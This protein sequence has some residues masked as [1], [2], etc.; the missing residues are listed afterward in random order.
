M[1]HLSFK[2]K[3][4]FLGLS[5]F[6]FITG[7]SYYTYKFITVN[8]HYTYLLNPQYNEQTDLQSAY[9]IKGN[10]V[11]LG[12]SL[13]YRVHWNELLGRSDVINRGIGSDIMAGYLTRLQYVFNVNP[14]ICFVEGGIND[15]AKDIAIDTIVY[16][17]R[18]L[19]DTLECHNIKVVLNSTIHVAASYPNSEEVN[20]KVK[21]LNKRM[22]LE[23]PNNTIIDLNGIIAPN[24]VLEA[25]YAQKDGIH[26]TSKAYLIWKDKILLTLHNAQI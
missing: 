5:L 25:P 10:I 22:K 14:K 7:I 2:L 13:V 6:V 15:L 24:E 19:T 26:L 16:N 21:E 9:E 18:R 1:H 3:K 12:N 4:A 8:K 20:N 23:F 11:M 17:M